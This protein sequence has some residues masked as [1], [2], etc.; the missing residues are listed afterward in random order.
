[1]KHFL[2]TA[3][4]A[5]STTGLVAQDDLLPLA[6]G[7]S[8]PKVEVK[9]KSVDGNEFS[10]NDMQNKNGVLVFVAVK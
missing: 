2:L 9:M 3:W 1:M 6:I 7:S 5:F 10:I 4:I 8:I